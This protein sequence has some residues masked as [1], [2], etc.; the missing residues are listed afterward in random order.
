MSGLSSWDAETKQQVVQ[1]DKKQ[2]GRT[3]N[4]DVPKENE[5]EEG[6][7]VLQRLFLSTGQ[8]SG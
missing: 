5:K 8:L 4:E 6:P 2:E 3:K 7:R 1:F